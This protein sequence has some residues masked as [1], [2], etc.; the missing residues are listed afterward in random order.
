MYCKTSH[1]NL[2]F[3]RVYLLYLHK[4]IFAIIRRIGKAIYPRATKA[5]VFGCTGKN[6]LSW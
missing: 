2:M 5:S 6:K 3:G 4:V 1:L